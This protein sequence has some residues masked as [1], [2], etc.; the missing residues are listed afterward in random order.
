[1]NPSPKLNP[2]LK[3]G[4]RVYL[5]HM[6]G[7]TEVTSGDRGVV[8]GFND[9][10]NETQYTMKWDNGHTYDLIPSTDRYVLEKD[11]LSHIQGEK[12]GNIDESSSEKAQ[13][14]MGRMDI[15][16]H[17]DVQKL[18]NYLKMVQK[19]GITN[20]FQSP[21]YL[22]IGKKKIKEEMKYK[23]L[24][25]DQFNDMLNNADMSRDLMIQGT[26]KYLNSINK[27]DSIENI[28]RYV[29]RLAKNMVEVYMLIY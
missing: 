7:E 11:F 19:S 25:G 23:D 15:L 20:M 27:E 9:F 17:F 10:R 5:L 13:K 21:P 3:E 8:T 26:M 18:H 22:Y 16:S 2:E 1:M 28:S 6:Y 14:L 12:S 24:S 4:D 29:P